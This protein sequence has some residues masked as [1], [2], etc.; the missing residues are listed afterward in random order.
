M[1]YLHNRTIV[2]LLGMLGSL[3]AVAQSSLVYLGDGALDTLRGRYIQAGQVVNFGVQMVSTWSASDGS[4]S[5]VGMA[6]Q[7]K[8]GFEP[9]LTAYKLSSTPATTA[10]A[11]SPGL[12]QGLSSMQG[13]AQVNQV[14]GN[15]NKAGNTAV[16]TI[17]ANDQQYDFAFGGGWQAEALGQG[18]KIEGNAVRVEIDQGALGR[19]SQRIGNGHLEQFTR[20]QGDRI[21]VQNMLQIQI[22]LKPDALSTANSQVWNSLH[23]TLVGLN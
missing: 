11:S 9:N 2:L 15:G 3:P 10:T 4:T 6:L 8:P 16:I 23:N 12:P 21:A 13:V 17:S 14:A 19:A 20:I 5:G 22:V 1:R 7:L 18:V